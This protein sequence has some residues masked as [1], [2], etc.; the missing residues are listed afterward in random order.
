[1]SDVW[2]GPPFPVEARQPCANPEQ[3]S[4]VAA[5]ASNAVGRVGRTVSLALALGLALALYGAPASAQQLPP[6]P[7]PVPVTLDPSTAALVVL[8]I[9]TQTCSPQAAAA[10]R[11]LLDLLGSD[12]VRGFLR[13]TTELAC[14]KTGPDHRRKQELNPLRN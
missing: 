3:A 7:S 1:V 9:T 14:H 12:P 10:V 13:G 4:L 11:W 6:A 5:M 2:H 8:D